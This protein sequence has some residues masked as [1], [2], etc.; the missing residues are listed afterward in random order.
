M[1]FYPEIDLSVTASG[2]LTIAENKDLQMAGA[3]G[4]LKQDIRFRLKTEIG[5]FIPHPDLGAGLEEIIGEPNTRETARI[6]ESKIIQALTYDNR[7]RG[8]DLLV[9]GVP[10]SL[11]NVSFYVFVRNGVE[12]VN[13]T[14]DL[15]IDLSR[16]VV[17]Y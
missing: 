17:S 1:Y 2:D 3:A 13:V 11:Y 15:Y 8:G 7:I 9:K 5:D 10:I 16:G 6:G 14:P 12:M 4:V